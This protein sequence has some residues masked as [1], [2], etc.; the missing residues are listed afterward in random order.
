MF[1]WFAEDHL[2]IIWKPK[3]AQNILCNLT[4]STWLLMSPMSLAPVLQEAPHLCIPY[5]YSIWWRGRRGAHNQVS[6]RSVFHCKQLSVT[7]LDLRHIATLE[8][9]EQNPRV[10]SCTNNVFKI[11]RCDCDS[12]CMNQILLVTHRYVIATLGANYSHTGIHW[13]PL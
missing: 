8:T 11:G 12:M 7:P 9:I 5:M 6:S 1:L 10:T 4:L 13:D 2:K 3:A